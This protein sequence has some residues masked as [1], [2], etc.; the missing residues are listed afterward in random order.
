MLIQ[1]LTEEPGL[2][3]GLGFVIVAT[4]MLPARVRWYVFTAGTAIIAFRAY[5]IYWARG[6]I[7]KLDKERDQLRNELK[8]LRGV[9][10]DPFVIIYAVI[11]DQI[12]LLHLAH[13]DHVYCSD[14]IFTPAQIAELRLRFPGFDKA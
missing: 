13:H 8:G 6:R 2:F 4:I 1:L 12:V 14:S 9:H 5:Q 11:D 3:I 10:V 7:Q